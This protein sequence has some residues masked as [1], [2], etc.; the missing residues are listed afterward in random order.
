MTKYSTTQTH[1]LQDYRRKRS[2]TSCVTV[3]IAI[4]S[5]EVYSIVL[6]EYKGIKWYYKDAS[7]NFSEIN[8]RTNP[9]L[10]VINPDSSLTVKQ[11]GEFSFSKK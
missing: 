11:G 10:A 7:G 6:K 2:G 4:N 8:D 5:S 1:K 3:P 9:A